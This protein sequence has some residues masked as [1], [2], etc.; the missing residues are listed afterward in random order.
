MEKLFKNSVLEKLFN[1]RSE[2]LSYKII[3]NSKEYQELNKRMENRIKQILNY[4]PGEHYEAVE[5]DIDD[6]LFDHVLKLA[7]F[8]NARY[9]KIGFSDGLRVKKEVEQSL[10]E[11]ANEQSIR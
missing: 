3:K 11:L 2:E 9:Y 5:K 1:S 6:F 10:E 8:W 7:E 4:V